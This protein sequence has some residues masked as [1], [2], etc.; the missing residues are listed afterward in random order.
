M[1]LILV[2]IQTMI[3]NITTAIQTQ[4]PTMI[5]MGVQILQNIATGIVQM[6]PQ[7]VV[8]AIQI[9]TTLIIQS[10]ENSLQSLMVQ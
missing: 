7:L 10:D 3:T 2:G 8:G 4:L 1:P 6:L 5:Q 9:I